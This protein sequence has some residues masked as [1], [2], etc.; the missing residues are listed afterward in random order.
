M[1]RLLLYP[2]ALVACAVPASAQGNRFTIPSNQPEAVFEGA[3]LETVAG[4]LASGCMDRSWMISVQGPNQV[5]CEFKL[6][7]VNAALAKVFI[8][9]RYSSQPRAFT[10]FSLVQL[11]ANVRG[12][13]QAWIETQTAFGQMRQE[14]QTGPHYFD[15]LVWMLVESGGML[16]DGS[17]IL[18]RYLGIDGEVV[19]AGTCCSYRIKQI[20]SGSPAKLAGLEVGDGIVRIGGKTFRNPS[21]FFAR[22]AKAPIGS[23]LPVVYL[24]EGQEH[25]TS[26]TVRE[27]PQPGSAEFRQMSADLIGQ[28]P[29]TQTP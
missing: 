7:P 25:E 5:V 8:G 4:R 6:D 13:A 28:Q 20:A 14:P 22:F 12:Q 29:K 26:L 19:A 15:S 16:P 24:R 17:H 3:S 18:G 10:R 11:G 27:W 2:A 23:T 1:H 21:Q 9:N